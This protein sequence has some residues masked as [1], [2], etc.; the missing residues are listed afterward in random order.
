[1]SVFCAT[2]DES[3]DGTG[4]GVF[5]CSGADAVGDKADTPVPVADD[6]DAVET[7]SVGDAEAPCVVLL[8][9]HPA[10][11]TSSPATSD[12]AATP[13]NFDILLPPVPAT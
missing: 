10:T 2:A 6:V 12:D 8:L 1:M 4:L 11:A 13:M 3:D 7:C 9:E 5:A